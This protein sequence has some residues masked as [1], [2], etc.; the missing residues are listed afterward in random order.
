MGG[1]ED[2][3][4]LE[5]NYRPETLSSSNLSSITL[6]GRSSADIRA[7]E[8]IKQSCLQEEIPIEPIRLR[9]WDRRPWIV[10]IIFLCL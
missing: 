8:L 1:D 3:P 5:Y 2:G 4:C 9:E 7:I 10:R 6:F